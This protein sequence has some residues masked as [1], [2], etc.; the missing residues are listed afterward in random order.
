MWVPDRPGNMLGGV[1]SL[2]K[3]NNV[4]LN[5]VRGRESTIFVPKHNVQW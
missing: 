1:G 2:D 3:V 5:T 4:N